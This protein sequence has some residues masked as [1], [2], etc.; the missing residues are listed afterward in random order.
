L[1]ALLL[2]LGLIAA[3]PLAQAQS[4]AL[5]SC[6]ALVPRLEQDPSSQHGGVPL[7]GVDYVVEDLQSTPDSRLCTGVAQYRDATTHI[8]WS[9]TWDDPKHT[10]FDVNGHETNASEAESR[11]TTLRVRNHPP[12][13][14]GT[15]LLRSMVP[16]C[17]DA[18]FAKLV[19]NE[20]HIGISFRDTFYREPSY[21]VVAMSSNG[22]GSGVVINCLATVGNGTIKGAIFIGTDW[23]DANGRK[24]QLYILSPGPDGFA[25]KNRLWETATE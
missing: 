6:K 20:L 2:A 18:N 13:L 16:Y 14:D 8:T 24:F 5:P 17:E 15:F 23:S 3:A 9:A 4:T 12:G 19:E 1:H 10:V 21:S 7:L 22:Y 25:L 11:A